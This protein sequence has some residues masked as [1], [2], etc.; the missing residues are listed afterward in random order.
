MKKI[1]IIIPTE[2]D[3]ERLTEICNMVIDLI[4]S[5]TNNIEEKAFILKTIVEGFQDA[6]KAKIPIE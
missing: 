6:A 3:K 1:H 4:E 2:E 5:R